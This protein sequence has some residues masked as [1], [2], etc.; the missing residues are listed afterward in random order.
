MVLSLPL[1]P[2][3]LRRHAV[4]KSA[5]SHPLPPPP[6]LISLPCLPLYPQPEMT[7]CL[8]LESTSPHLYIKSSSALRGYC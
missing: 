7:I 4:C 8:V 5:L 6:P 3:V 1:V 2:L